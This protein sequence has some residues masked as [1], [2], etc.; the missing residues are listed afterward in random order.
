MTRPSHVSP[1]LWGKAS[2][3]VRALLAEQHQTEPTIYSE[4]RE[5]KPDYQK[6]FEAGQYKSGSSKDDRTFD[7]ELFQTSR[8][9]RK[10]C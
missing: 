6:A 3:A 7:Y 2:P 9:T 5:R 4:R 8:W 10:E 1:R